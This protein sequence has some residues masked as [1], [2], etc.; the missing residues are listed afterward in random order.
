MYGAFTFSLKF[1]CANNK[2]VEYIAQTLCI[3]PQN[4]KYF[5][6]EFYQYKIFSLGVA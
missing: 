6:E 2:I 4:I 5:G 1:Y 3:F